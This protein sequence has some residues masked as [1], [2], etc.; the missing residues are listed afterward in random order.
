MLGEMFCVIHLCLK[1]VEKS[2]LIMF[3]LTTH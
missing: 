3:H 2:D 1:L